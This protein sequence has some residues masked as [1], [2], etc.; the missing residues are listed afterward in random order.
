M[1]YVKKYKIIFVVMGAAVLLFSI[2]FFS[3]KQTGDAVFLNSSGI[4]S[5]KLQ[6]SDTLT[7]LFKD[8][9]I[10]D[11]A[12]VSF[13]EINIVDSIAEPM[14]V[15]SDKEGNMVISSR[16][17]IDETTKVANVTIS[18]GEFVENLSAE[19]QV[20]WLDSE[21]Y[22]NAEIIVKRNLK[23]TR[24]ELPRIKVFVAI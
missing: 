10:I 14:F 8:N 24:A 11:N 23:A 15:Q 6:N 19:E 22:K 1:E 5:V 9:N 21:F 12:N 4:T 2:L 13:V 17:D 20:S 7:S 16:F 18:L 3:S